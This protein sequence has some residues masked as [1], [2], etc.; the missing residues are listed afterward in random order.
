MNRALRTLAAA[1]VRC[2]ALA[3]AVPATSRAA[4]APER[5]SAPLSD[6]AIAWNQFLLGLQATP[7]DQPATVH[8]T[9]ELAI[10]HA[11]VY[12]AV[13]SID[14]DAAPF[15]AGVRGE[16][17]AAAAADAAAHD[18]LVALYPSLR[19]SID[20][21]YATLIGRLPPGRSQAHAILVGRRV[22]SQILRQRANDG[23]AAAPTPF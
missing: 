19:S 7:G 17:G 20:Q 13:V 18:T 9:Y 11:A 5:P 23:S 4:T 2:A 6:P 12:D 14:R 8:P 21:Q 16:R 1:A 3:A 22:A 10:M 15:L